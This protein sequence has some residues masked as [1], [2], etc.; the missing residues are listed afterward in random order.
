MGSRRR[1]EEFA[2]RSSHGRIVVA[3]N[4]TNP[5]HNAISPYPEP[6]AHASLISHANLQVSSREL[7]LTVPL[8]LVH[9][10]CSCQHCLLTGFIFRVKA[11]QPKE[12][13]M[14]ALL[15][16]RYFAS[17]GSTRWRRARHR[18]CTSNAVTM[19]SC[20]CVSAAEEQARSLAMICLGRRSA[21]D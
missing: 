5:H 16:C 6:C 17:T 19:M 21:V 20:F 15:V 7:K 2:G 13:R 8:Y 11:D 3:C 14:L 12:S 18:G 1:K 9:F 10:P 4:K